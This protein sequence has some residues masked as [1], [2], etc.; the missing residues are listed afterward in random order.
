MVTGKVT[1][2]NPFG[3]FVQLT[4]KIQGLCHIS[5]FG[6]QKK[7]EESLEIG[8]EYNFKI[9]SVEPAE[10]RITLKLEEK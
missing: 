1:K 5:E 7:M 4:P 9:L 6:S 8:K 10:H 2:F 3:A